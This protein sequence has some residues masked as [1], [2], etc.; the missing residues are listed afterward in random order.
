MKKLYLLK[1]ALALASLLMVFG[2]STGQAQ[3]T[4]QFGTGTINNAGTG[5]PA[6]YGN[7]YW[8]ARHQ[9]LIPACDLA[10][11][12]LNVD[13]INGLAWDVASAQGTPLLDFTISIGNTSAT[14]LTG[15]VGGLTQVYYDSAYTDTAGWN[16][17]MFDTM[18]VNNP[19]QS[20]VIEV[21]FNNNGFTNNPV[22]LGL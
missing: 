7:W 12:G 6:P 9:F 13:S 20:L 22:A 19:A 14:D 16:W 2:L 15:W 5:Y 3:D 1:A 8:G 21:C 17:H 10:D 18:F 11:L 4:L